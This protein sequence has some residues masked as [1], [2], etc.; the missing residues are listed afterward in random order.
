MNTIDDLLVAINNNGV[1][2]FKRILTEN[3][4]LV[5]AQNSDGETPLHHAAYMG[6]IEIM[7]FLIRKDADPN[8]QNIVEQTPLH[9]ACSS[10]RDPEAIKLLISHGADVNAKD[11]RERTPLHIACFSGSDIENIRI[12]IENGADVNAEDEYERTPLIYIDDE[13][14]KHNSEMEIEKCRLLI[15][16]GANVHSFDNPV[17]RKYFK[18]NYKSEQFF[19]KY[20]PGTDCTICMDSL[21]DQTRPVCISL[22][23]Q[24]GFHCECINRWLNNGKDTCPYCRK[25]FD[26]IT[27]N[28]DD[29]EKLKNMGFGKRK[30]RKRK[31]HP[32]TLKQVNK[33]LKMLEKI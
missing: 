31:V 26:L 28:T 15:E 19:D 7:K 2:Q 32:L 1:Y 24:H 14:H 18:K 12:L 16:K 8:A 4:E 30:Y 23:C 6:N 17:L 22:N 21:S 25:P 29:Q 11:K 5:N 27:L 20:E 9:Y 3:S 13:F 33:M 10:G